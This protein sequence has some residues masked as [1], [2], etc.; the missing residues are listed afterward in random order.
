MSKT[1]IVVS[2]SGG[3]TSATLIETFGTAAD[4]I[5]VNTGF[6]HPKTY[7][8]LRDLVK[9]YGINLIC[10]EPVTQEYGKSNTYKVV[11]VETIGINPQIMLD[12]VTKYGSFTVGVPNCSERM[13]THTMEAY[14]KDHYAGIDHKHVIGFRVDEQKRMLGDKGYKL[15]RSL[16]YTQDDVCDL[17]VRWCNVLDAGGNAALQKD[18]RDRFI[19]IDKETEKQIKSLVTKLRYLWRLKIHYMAE[20]SDF[21][22]QDVGDFWAAM[23]FTLELEEHQGN[24]VLCVKKDRKKVALA[25]RDNPELVD[26]WNGIIAKRRLM[27][28]YDGDRQYRAAKRYVT[29]DDVIAEF[30]HIPTEELREWVYKTKSK[31]EDGCGESCDP[32]SSEL[33]Q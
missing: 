22:K 25:A 6:E 23:P 12:H 33:S 26:I 28:A 3:L 9:H 5:F 31:D 11:P 15:I 1:K 20:Y 18:I 4:Y 14:K 8:F 30:A 2:L 10:L 32:F 16:G 7:K 24:C 29:L 17:K 19:V 27:P 21:D 13:K